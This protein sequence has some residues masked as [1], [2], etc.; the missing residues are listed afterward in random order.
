MSDYLLIKI[1]VD[2]NLGGEREKLCVE[3]LTQLKTLP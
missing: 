3:W 2:M 1:R